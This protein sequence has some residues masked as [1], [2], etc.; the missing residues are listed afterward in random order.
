MEYVKLNNGVEMP[1]VG[2]GTFQIP[3]EKMNDVIGWAYSEGYRMFDTARKYRNE[4]ALAGAFKKNGIK[5]EDVFLT[6][7][8]NVEDFYFWGIHGGKKALLDVRN[9]KSVK[10]VILESFKNLNTDYLDLFLVHWPWPIPLAQEIYVELVR[11]QKEGKI[12][13]VGVCSSLPP[14]I[15]AF[16]DAAGVVPAINQFEISP[17]NTQ[18]QLIKYCK[19]RGICVEAMSTFSHYRNTETRK[20]IVGNEEIAPIAEKYGKSIP[21]VILRWLVQQGVSVIPKSSNQGRLKENISIF[22]FELSAEEMGIIDGLDQ[23]RF[24]NYKPDVTLNKPYWSRG[25]FPKKYRGW[26][27][28]TE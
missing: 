26:N 7:K 24:L 10:K 21:Q 28:F 20:D 9:F 15:D 11:M 25:R 17:L 6:S 8:C 27:G 1:M 22:D 12:R 13:A 2:L 23:G 19:D 18:K 16:V 3:L 14:H 4:A 5:R